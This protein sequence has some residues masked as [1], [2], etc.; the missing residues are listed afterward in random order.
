MRA[1]DNRGAPQPSELAVRVAKAYY[2]EDKSKIQIADEFHISRFKVARLLTHARETGMVSISIRETP[3]P[4]RALSARLRHELGVAECF[5]VRPAGHASAREQVAM[6]GA[7][8]LTTRLAP[9]DIVGFSWGRTLAAMTGY[10]G[11]IPPI[12]AIQL[13]GS[14]GENLAISPVEILRRVVQVAGG[15]ADPIM[16]PILVDN[17]DAANAIR[18]QPQIQRTFEAFND[19]TIACLS[20]G[21]WD[22]CTSQL[23]EHLSDDDR[24][25]LAAAGAV[26]EV[27]GIFLD[28][29]GRLLEEL[30]DRLIGIPAHQLIKAPLRLV[31]AEDPAKAT[32]VLAAIRAGLINA[33]VIDATLGE[34]LLRLAADRP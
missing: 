14:V 19:L 34:E 8:F 13:N 21:S 1:M 32:I 23:V 25:R 28:R 10:L 33:L 27:A 18:R 31:I 16:A 11:V 7:A 20:A 22:P 9:E 17:A 6:A 5:V 29:D 30:T 2:L 24:T 15:H 4:E 26:G 3:S 12:R